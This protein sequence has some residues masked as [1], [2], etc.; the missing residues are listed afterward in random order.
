MDEVKKP[1]KP[2]I[3]Y[4]AVVML[5]VMLLN[6]FAVPALNA[7]EVKEVDYATFMKATENHEISEV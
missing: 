7:K 3:Y 5:A 4:Y 6:L 2:M 1:K